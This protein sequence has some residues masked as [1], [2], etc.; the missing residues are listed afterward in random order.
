MESEMAKTKKP[1]DIIKSA[2]ARKREYK[3]RMADAIRHMHEY[4][5]LYTFVINCI[6]VNDNDMVIIDEESIV[7]SLYNLSSLK[8]ERLLNGLSKIM[9]LHNIQDRGTH[10]YPGALNRDFKFVMDYMKADCTMG[11]LYISVNAYVSSSSTTC[12][13]VQTGVR[14]EPVYALECD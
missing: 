6:D 5:G 9:D 4:R 12:R 11:R 14:Q 2:I 10:D 3:R 13:R 1:T 7:F 8:D